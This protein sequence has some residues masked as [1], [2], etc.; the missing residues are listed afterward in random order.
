MIVGFGRRDGGMAGKM[1]DVIRASAG[2]GDLLKGT[3]YM[4]VYE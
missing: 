3:K 4:Y 1:A 2:E